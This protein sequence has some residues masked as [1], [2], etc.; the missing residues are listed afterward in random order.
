M[1]LLYNNV[2]IDFMSLMCIRCQVF[3]INN[4]TIPPGLITSNTSVI[5]TGGSPANPVYINTLRVRITCTGL[6]LET[7]TTVS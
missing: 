2:L 5:F 6:Y 1:Y 4:T 3:D 7:E